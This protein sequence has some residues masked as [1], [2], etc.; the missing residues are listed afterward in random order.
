MKRR[1]R[2]AS[3]TTVV[4]ALLGWLLWQ[5]TPAQAVFAIASLSDPAKLATLG[6]RGANARLNKIVYWLDAARRKGMGPQTAIGF[7]QSLNHTREPR[8]SL[9]RESL[10]RNLKIG[11]E[12]GLLTDDNRRRLREGNAAVITL[13]PYAGEPA[14]IDHIIPHSLAPE[15]GNELANLEMLPKT[16]NREKSNRVGDRQLSH[17]KRLLDAGLLT[18]ESFARVKA[19]AR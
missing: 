13:G 17:A 19:A 7:A 15:A 11:E 12:L 5:F 4:V 10:L 2:K 18:P 16:L 3:L 6:E 8:A 1:R 9:V 14:E